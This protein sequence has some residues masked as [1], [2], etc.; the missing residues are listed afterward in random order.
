M[1]K[2]TVRSIFTL[3]SV[4][5]VRPKIESNR[6]KENWYVMMVII[7]MHASVINHLRRS[8]PLLINNVRLTKQ[9]EKLTRLSV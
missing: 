8:W 6:F 4:T 2:I 3:S 7:K 5:N 9:M 1:I